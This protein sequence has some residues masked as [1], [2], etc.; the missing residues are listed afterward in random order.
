MYPHHHH[1]PYPHL[2]SSP[3]DRL[4]I[5]SHRQSPYPS[6]YKRPEIGSSGKDFTYLETNKIKMIIEIWRYFHA[7]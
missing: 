5:R 1:R 3:Y 6:P 4:G 2:T 7:H